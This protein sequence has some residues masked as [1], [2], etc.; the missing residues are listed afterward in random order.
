MFAV[1]V[2]ANGRFLD[3][4]RPRLPVNALPPLLENLPVAL[5]ASFGNV[6]AG[7]FCVG[8]VGWSYAVNPVTI[9][10]NRRRFALRRFRPFLH[11]LP[12]QLT[13]NA[14]FVVKQRFA[15]RDLVPFNQLCVAVA[16]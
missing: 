12:K 4:F 10:A 2:G 1:T 3:A 14:P 9:G 6:R 13:V 8:V 5:T 11:A 15:L 16:L 7:Y